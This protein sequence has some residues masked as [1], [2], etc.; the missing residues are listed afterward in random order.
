MRWAVF[1]PFLSFLWLLLPLQFSLLAP[2][3][4]YLSSFSLSFVLSLIFFLVLLS[5]TSPPSLS[6]CSRLRLHFH[7][8]LLPFAFYG[9][10]FPWLSFFFHTPFSSSVF[11]FTSTSVISAFCLALIRSS[12]FMLPL[13]PLLSLRFHPILFSPISF[14]PSSNPSLITHIPSFL[15]TL[16]YCFT[17]IRFSFLP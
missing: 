17:S 14:L 10:H 15:F 1:E 7:L 12:Y 16:S 8:F 5:L 2:F 13:Y 11:S 3:I 9:F 4:H 6:F